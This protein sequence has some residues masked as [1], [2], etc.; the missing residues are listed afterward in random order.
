[1]AKAKSSFA[2]KAK[3][4]KGLVKKAR[5]KVSQDFGGDLEPGFHV[6]CL[7]KVAPME[8][9]NGWKV[10]FEFQA[11]DGDQVGD[12]AAIW[13]SME[14][15][16][17]ITWVMRHLSWLGVDPDEIDFE[18]LEEL[19]LEVTAEFKVVRLQVTERDGY[20]NVKNFK[21]IDDHDYADPRE[22]EDEDEDEAGSSGV[23]ATPDLSEEEC[24]ALAEWLT[25]KAAEV[26]ID[27]NAYATWLGLFEALCEVEGFVEAYNDEYGEEEPEEE[28][29]IFNE[30]E[31]R[32]MFCS[33]AE[34]HAEGLQELADLIGEDSTVYETWADFFLEAASR[35]A[36]FPQVTDLGDFI[37]EA[38]TY[39]KSIDGEDGQEEVNT[40]MVEVEFS[41][42]DKVKFKVGNK[43][44]K[45]KIVSY[46]EDDGEFAIKVQGQ[47]LP[48]M[49]TPD[50]FEI[51]D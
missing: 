8:T 31:I 42:G 1:M 20:N 9:T 11:I 10:L 48:V 13:D 12:R 33:Q 46:D 43:T 34:D 16:E 37:D 41:I 32:K 28:G 25:Q 45:G 15:E 51:D 5:A 39:F 35:L 4:I 14:T 24:E 47:R 3:K 7:K 18:K 29:D 50:E 38:R 21:I 26:D 44:K 40:E 2:S 17:N 6:C 23:I 49:L 19:C 22:D 27:P 36:E 30:E